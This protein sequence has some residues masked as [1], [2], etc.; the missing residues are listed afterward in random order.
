MIVA[1][2]FVAKMV[3]RTDEADCLYGQQ[4]I[5]GMGECGTVLCYAILY[6]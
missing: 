1:R 5:D 2:T 6:L 3:R 4:E